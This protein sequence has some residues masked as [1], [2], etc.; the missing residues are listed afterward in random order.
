LVLKTTAQ[1]VDAMSSIVKN[2]QKEVELIPKCA[3]NKFNNATY[4]KTKEELRVA[5]TLCLK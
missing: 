3:N 4:L 1:A 5:M 2:F